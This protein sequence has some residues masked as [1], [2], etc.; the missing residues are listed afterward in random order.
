MYKKVFLVILLFIGYCQ[1]V[2][3]ETMETDPEFVGGFFEGD[4]DLDLTRNGLIDT[5]KRWPNAIVRY[6]IDQ[7]FDID[8]TLYILKGMQIIESNSCIRFRHATDAATSYIQINGNPTGCS[9]FVGYRGS[10][11]NVN[12]QPDNLD[13]GC[14]RIGSVMHELLH[15]LGFHHEHSTFYRDDY[16]KVV[17]ENI[18]Q[19]KEPFFQ[20]YNASTVTGFGVS[21][22]Y[23]SVMHYPSAAFSKNGEKTLIPLQGE[24]I[25]I[26]QR[27]ELS[28]K[29]IRKLNLMYKCNV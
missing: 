23:G 5:S 15:A 8:H 21:Y 16:L 22:D 4:M 3:V 2:P 7:V 9:A 18:Q 12:L 26:G 14:F 10:K 6:K 13:K 24:N 17:W 28:D 27:R 25:E 1:A 29:D 11:Q 20:K 19:G